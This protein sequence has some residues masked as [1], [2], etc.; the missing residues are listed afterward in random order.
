MRRK[1]CIAVIFAFFVMLVSFSSYWGYARWR[2]NRIRE[3]GEECRQYQTKADWS[4]MEEAARRWTTIDPDSADPWLFL[5]IALQEQ[6]DLKTSAT[7]L[8]QLPDKD[9]K[10]IPGLLE[11][12][13]LQFGP[14]NKP[15]DGVATCHRILNINPRILEARRRI[16]FFYA[17]CLQR[18]KMTMQIYQGIEFA[19][20]PRESYVYLMLGDAPVFSNGFETANHWLQNEP[21]SELFLVA[22]TVQLAEN[23]AILKV[24]TSESKAQLERA[25]QILTDYRR[26]FPGNTVVLWYFLKSAVRRS[27]IEETGNLLSKISP[28]AGDESVFWK[29]R[30]WYHAQVGEIEEAEA[31]Y[32][33]AASL[34]P[35]DSQ[36]WHELADVLRRRG[37]LTEAESAQNIAATGRQLRLELQKLKDAATVSDIQLDKIRRYAET[38]GDRAVSDALRRRLKIF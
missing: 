36:V 29:Y 28:D 6:G 10:T 23:L 27:D 3:V 11:L 21:D 18:T 9:P 7:V 31:A 37:R 15:L 26:Q 5:A 17:I 33:K 13:A 16:I 38:C 2:E 34:T 1:I 35:L 12:S 14:L 4:R 25:E 8:N 19:C 32:V 22:R 24:P 20:E 30:G